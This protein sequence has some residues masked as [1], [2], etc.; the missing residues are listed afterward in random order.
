MAKELYSVAG[1]LETC[2]SFEE[3]EEATCSLA[4]HIHLPVPAVALRFGWSAM[5]QCDEAQHR[6]FAPLQSVALP[7][8]D[9]QP[10]SR[11]HRAT[12]PKLLLH[13]LGEPHCFQADQALIM[14]IQLRH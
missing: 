7:Q 3:H 12:F 1:L 11:A 6:L 5:R 14:A 13:A 2:G 9:M 10:S 8:G 4:V